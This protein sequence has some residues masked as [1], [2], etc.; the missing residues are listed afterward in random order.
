MMIRFPA[1]ISRRL[2]A[3]ATLLCMA[4]F[5]TESCT[6]SEF[7]L[8]AGGKAEKQGDGEV[9][10]KYKLAAECAWQLDLPNQ[11]RFDASGLL[12]RQGKLLTISDRSSELWQ[13]EPSTNSHR[14]LKPTGWFTRPEIAKASGKKEPGYD[15][16]AIA[17]DD[18]GNLYISEEH[19]RVIYR[20]NPGER[21]VKKL[22]IDWTPVERYFSK[23]DE[24]ASFEGIAVGN[25]KLWVANERNDPRI[26]VVDLAT[27]KVEESFFVDATSF[28]FG[29]PHYSDLSWFEGKLYVLDRN[30]RVVLQVNP[31]TKKVTAEYDFGEM[32]LGPEVAYKTFYPT[33]TM[34]G[35]AVDKDYIWLV[36]DNNGKGRFKYPDDLRPTLFKCR[37][38]DRKAD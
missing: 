19:D 20:L 35:L 37:R 15:C 31:N 26:I 18:S 4:L 24:N 16:E 8:N 1:R 28:A 2:Q 38:P 13:I 25:G 36:T 17:K 7:A 14:Q 32:E 34:E 12:F 22:S 23:F 30:H 33:G 21:K 27:L 6:H 11:R 29:G 10:H 9:F 3:H 5:L